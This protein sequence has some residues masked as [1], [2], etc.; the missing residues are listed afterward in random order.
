MSCR[1]GSN[2][3]CPVVPPYLC[4]IGY[5]KTG[6]GLGSWKHPLEIPVANKLNLGLFKKFALND[7]SG[8]EFRAEAFDFLN[9]PN[10]SAPNFNPTAA[11]FGKVT[12]K[13]TLARNLQL[14]LRLYF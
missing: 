3:T 1:C 7:R 13:T 2:G 12:T 4:A 8:F 6:C 11:T 5:D 10:W 14:S 9:H